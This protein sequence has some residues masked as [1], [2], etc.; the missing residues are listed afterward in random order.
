MSILTDLMTPKPVPSEGIE[1]ISETEFIE[2]FKKQFRDPIYDKH[3]AAIQEMAKIAYDAHQEGGHKAPFTKPAGPGY[4]DPSYKLADDWTN[5]K[6][7]CDA[8]RLRYEDKSRKSKVLIIS[9]ANRN[10]KTCPGEVSKSRRMA[11]L[12]QKVFEDEFQFDVEL[13][14][15]SLITSEY[16]KQI[17][18]C[19]GCVSTAMPLCHFPCS[20]YPNH[21][22]GQSHDWMNELYPKFVESHALLFVTPVYWYQSPS[23]LKLL[24]DRL[25]CVNGGNPDPTS[26]HGKKAEEAKKIEAGGWDYPQ[27]LAR[28]I[29]GCIVHGDT[30][31]VT[32]LKDHLTNWAEDLQMIPASTKSQIGRYIGYYGPYFE[33]HEAYE[34]DEK[35]KQ[36]VQM[37]ARSIAH[38]TLAERSD[39]NIDLLSPEIKEPRQK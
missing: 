29:F 38:T 16:G 15:L 4:K 33:S 25:V 5:T 21:S 31:G 7:A 9:G 18:P 17:H 39:R 32:A 8:A 20:C 14:D 6:A 36:E 35:I 30:T 28:R 11:Q 27:H 37:V 24:I 26:T 34:K 13:I 12:A 10:D 2:R 23:A 22:L 3:R 1:P 19:K